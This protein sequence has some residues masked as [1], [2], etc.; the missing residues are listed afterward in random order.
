MNKLLTIMTIAGLIFTNISYTPVG[1]L[2]EESSI[3]EMRISCYNSKTTITND[4]V[5]SDFYSQFSSARLKRLNYHEA[6]KFLDWRNIANSD[7]YV[8]LHSYDIKDNEKLLLITNTYGSYLFIK[9][10][11]EFNVYKINDNEK[12]SSFISELEV[13]LD[14]AMK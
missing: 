10:E 6:K 11:S 14:N 5:I 1:L 13:L 12:F 7:V 3:D 4:N 2:I 8:V 9:S